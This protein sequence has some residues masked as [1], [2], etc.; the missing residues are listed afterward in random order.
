VTDSAEL[1]GAIPTLRRK[2]VCVTLF[3]A[4]EVCVTL[5]ALLKGRAA[6]SPRQSSADF[7]PIPPPPVKI[8]FWK[9]QASRTSTTSR[10]QRLHLR[11]RKIFDAD[12]WKLTS[13]RP[14]NC[15]PFSIQRC[16]LGIILE[17]EVM[18]VLVSLEPTGY[19]SSQPRRK[20]QFSWLKVTTCN[21]VS[22]TGSRKHSINDYRACVHQFRLKKGKGD[23]R[24][25][26]TNLRALLRAEVALAN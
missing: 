4:V 26:H 9:G 1:R 3:R 24:V 7:T 15:D 19:S 17:L 2:I 20:I 16:V 22:D 25:T 8:S 11:I 13:Q 10:C 5:S 23:E 12:T 21:S 18:R 6:S 14:G